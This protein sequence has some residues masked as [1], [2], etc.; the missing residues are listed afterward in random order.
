MYRD[1]VVMIAPILDAA[2]GSMA[3]GVEKDARGRV[4]DPPFT[5]VRVP[6]PGVLAA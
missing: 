1:R 2:D 3:T 4:R 5:T 6:R